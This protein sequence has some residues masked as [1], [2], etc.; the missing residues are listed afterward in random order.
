MPSELQVSPA[1]QELVNLFDSRFF[2]ALSEPA[3]VEILKLLIVY[4]RADIAAISQHLPQDRSVI[5][6]HLKLM[7]EAGI[8]VREK[9]GRHVYYQV[10]A[11][12]IIGRLETILDQVKR[13]VAACCP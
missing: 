6:R 2:A 3:R 11:Q 12:G 8:L 7:E 13:A 4:G 5:S 10:S 9:E 1:A